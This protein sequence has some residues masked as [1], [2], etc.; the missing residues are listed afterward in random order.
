M[1]D[2]SNKEII[3]PESNVAYYVIDGKPIPLQRPRFSKD[4]HVWDCQT[5]EKLGIQLQLKSQHKGDPFVGPLKLEVTFFMPIPDKISKKRLQDLSATPHYCRPDIDN[6]QKMLLDC[7]NSIIYAD[8]ALIAEITARKI[9]SNCP[10]TEFSITRLE[11]LGECNNEEEKGDRGD[12][13][14]KSIV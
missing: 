1:E 14:Q 11:P 5:R 2:M 6:L 13:G 7:A 8:D 12:A 9:W 10:R 4:G 3:Q